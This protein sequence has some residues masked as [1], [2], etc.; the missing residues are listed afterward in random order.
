MEE[1][2]KYYPFKSDKVGKKYYIITNDNKKVYFGASEYEHFT[3]GHLDERRK[4]AY[5]SRHRKNEDWK[6]PNTA[7]Y[8]IQK[9]KKRLERKRFHLNK[10]LLKLDNS[11]FDI[12]STFS[13]LL[14]NVFNKIFLLLLF[15]TI[16][17]RSNPSC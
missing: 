14:S 13:T 7:G 11:D 15:D 12:F 17:E 9:N 1:R 6:N 8:W 4:L 10:L 5:I 16:L 3:E 2:K